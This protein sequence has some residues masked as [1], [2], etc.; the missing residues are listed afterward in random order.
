MQLP[1]FHLNGSSPKSLGEEYQK[2][3]E[4]FEDFVENFSRV[5]FHP[6][7]YY[8]QEGAWDAAYKEREE[9]K[10]CLQSLQK[11]LESHTIHCFNHTK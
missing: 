4:S 9:A 10:K 11:Y 5:E 2:A 7:D 8:V 1:I 3:L 6:R